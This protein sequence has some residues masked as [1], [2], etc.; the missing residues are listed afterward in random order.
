MLKKFSLDER[1][2]SY[3]CGVLQEVGELGRCLAKQLRRHAAS[4]FTFGPSD[5]SPSHLYHFSEGGFFQLP[6]KVL[7]TT[8]P[9]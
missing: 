7:T 3:A 6:H 2:V 9:E 8:R 4:S 1:A 5:I